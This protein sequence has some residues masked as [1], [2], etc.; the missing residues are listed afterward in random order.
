MEAL[1]RPIVSASVV[2]EGVLTW[3]M[4]LAVLI[5]L[6]IWYVMLVRRRHPE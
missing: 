4:P 3:A 2:A 6:V 1:L 5:A